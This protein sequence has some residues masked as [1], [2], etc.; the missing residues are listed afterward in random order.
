MLTSMYL[1]P[2]YFFIWHRWKSPGTSHKQRNIQLPHRSNRLNR[3]SILPGYLDSKAW[4]FG[5]SESWRRSAS[6]V[7][8]LRDPSIPRKGAPALKLFLSRI[9][10]PMKWWPSEITY[11]GS[12][13]R[14]SVT[15]PIDIFTTTLA[16][17]CQNQWFLVELAVS[18]P[19]ERSFLRHRQG[20]VLFQDF[21]W[22]S[23]CGAQ[24]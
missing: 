12:L 5:S 21:Q 22:R 1:K 13:S 4:G 24:N 7:L 3:V 14:I 9:I 6:V 15:V 2:I 8:P 18:A 20:L 17:D 11:E 19:G 23:V 10:A 16:S